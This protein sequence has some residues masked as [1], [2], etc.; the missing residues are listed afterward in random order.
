[1]RRMPDPVLFTRAAESP[2]ADLA[3]LATRMVKVMRASPACVGVAAPQVGELVRLFVMDVGGHKK[4]IVNNGLVVLANPVVL[5][6]TGAEVGR[7][8]CLSVPDLTGDVTRSTRIVVSGLDPNTLETRVI[9]AENFEA[10]VVQHELDHLDGLLFL[11]RVGHPRHLY[12]RRR[13]K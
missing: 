3:A 11:D 2:A 4:A 13:Y 12:G 5:D 7:E 8:G 9:E 6:R 1:M 10:R